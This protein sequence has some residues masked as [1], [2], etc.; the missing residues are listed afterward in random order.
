[1]PNSR[2]PTK[3]YVRFVDRAARELLNPSTAIRQHP[4]KPRAAET[5]ATTK[6]SK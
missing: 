4:S 2:Q 6:R 3:A 1:M 5:T